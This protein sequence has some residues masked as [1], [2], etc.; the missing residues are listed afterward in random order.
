[1]QGDSATMGKAYSE[2]AVEKNRI[3]ERAADSNRLQ[4]RGRLRAAPSRKLREALA[5][6]S[7]KKG[8]KLRA[9]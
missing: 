9:T 5:R 4:K 1:M 7:S 8:E 2:G 6:G 3:C